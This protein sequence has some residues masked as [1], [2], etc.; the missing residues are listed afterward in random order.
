M[1]TVYSG[2]YADEIGYDKHEGY[3]AAVLAN[4]ADA[5]EQIWLAYEDEADH[6]AARCACGWRGKGQHVVTDAGEDQ[7]L[8]EWRSYHLQ[9]LIDQVRER[10]W[11]EW[12]RRTTE[13]AK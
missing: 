7:A 10:S 3:A 6:L 2:P 4:G 8:A 11:P 13:R 12:T 1:G 9:P 5:G